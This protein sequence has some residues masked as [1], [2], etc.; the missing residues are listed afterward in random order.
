[1]GLK[2]I[3]L[4]PEKKQIAARRVSLYPGYD[5]LQI[6]KNYA[7]LVKID[8]DQL[9]P[10]TKALTDSPEDTLKDKT[11]LDELE[12]TLN[13]ESESPLPIDTRVPEILAY[14]PELD[15]GTSPPPDDGSYTGSDRDEK[16]DDQISHLVADEVRPLD[17]ANQWASV[18]FAFLL[19]QSSRRNYTYSLTLG[20]MLFMRSVNSQDSLSLELG[21][22]AFKVIRFMTDFD[23]YFV[24]PL[25]PTLR[26]NMYFGENWVWYFYLGARYNIILSSTDSTVTGLKKLNTLIPAI[27]TG[28]MVQF[29]PKWFARADFGLEMIAFGLTLK[30]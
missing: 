23:S 21:A 27:G 20:K 11:D 13:S 25:V 28:L 2:I 18:Q 4:Y 22:F 24:L 29:G 12:T 19:N 16:E 26:Y 30:F 1:M 8:S 17:T 3:K 9:E 6:A 7:G 14:D 10:S 5:E 15:A